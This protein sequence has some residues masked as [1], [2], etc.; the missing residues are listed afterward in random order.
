M[1]KKHNCFRTFETDGCNE[2][3]PDNAK[4]LHDQPE[5]RMSEW[6]SVKDRLP[7]ECES[8]LVWSKGFDPISAFLSYT[9]DKKPLMYFV[10]DW[11]ES[12]TNLKL[13]DVTHWMPLPE[14]PI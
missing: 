10:N 11:D 2:P 12:D 6:I 3:F 8:V 5:R 4:C 7:P 1:D 9:Y 13:E 14:P